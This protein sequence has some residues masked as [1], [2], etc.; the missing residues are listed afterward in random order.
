[1]EV[2]LLAKNDKTAKRIYEKWNDGI[3]LT[4]E[5]MKKYNLVLETIEL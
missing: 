5:H 2:L 1:M 4:L 3:K